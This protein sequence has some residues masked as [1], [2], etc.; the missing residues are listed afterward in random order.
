VGAKA[1]LMTID[2]SSTLSS[3]S[4]FVILLDQHLYGGLLLQ[5]LAKIVVQG[6]QAWRAPA[7]PGGSCPHGRRGCRGVPVVE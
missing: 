2:F 6:V 5:A 3:L 7:L 1:A 4:A